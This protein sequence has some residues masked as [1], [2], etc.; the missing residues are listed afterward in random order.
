V[1]VAVWTTTPCRIDKLPQYGYAT[2]RRG[3]EHRQEQLVRAYLGSAWRYRS[4][5]FTYR[6]PQ[7]DV[8]KVNQDHQALPGSTSRGLRSI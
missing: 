2:A 5:R 8:D 6:D 1:T 4:R 7:H 3:C